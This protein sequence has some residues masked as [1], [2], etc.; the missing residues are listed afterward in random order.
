M[1][2]IKTSTET[3]TIVDVSEINR[4]AR[5]LYGRDP[6]IVASEEWR[7]DEYHSITVEGRIDGW[8]QKALEKYKETG[9]A[10][11]GICGILLEAF[12]IEGL[13]KPG[14]YFVKVYW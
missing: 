1:E 3:V 8:D 9:Y 2:K 7:N 4:V 12:A 10:S 5:C 11:Y 13:I 14:R 6:E